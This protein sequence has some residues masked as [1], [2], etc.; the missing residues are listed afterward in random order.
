MYSTSMGSIQAAI[1]KLLNCGYIKYE[2][3]IENGR[4]KKII[5]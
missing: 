3:A 2:E 4:Y 1:K 5:Q